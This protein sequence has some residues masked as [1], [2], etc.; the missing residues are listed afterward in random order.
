MQ[1]DTAEL[2]GLAVEGGLYGVF[3]CLFGVCGYDLMQRRARV[4]TQLSWPM[5]LAS[6]LLIIIATVRFVVDTAN[7]FVA[8]IRHDPRSLRIAYLTDVTQPLFTTR[9]SLLIV[10]LLIGDSFVNYRCWVVWGKRIWIVLFPIGLSF[11][12]TAI[13]SY[14]M[15]AYGNLPNQTFLSES[16]WLKAFFALSLVANAVA[17]LLLAFRIWSLDYQMAHTT[18]LDR[19]RFVRIAIDSGALN[20]LFL[21]VYVMTLNFGSQGLGIMSGMAVPFTGIV[22]FIVILRIGRQRHDDSFF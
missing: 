1:I 20:G 19:A 2:A 8:F 7:I 9:H 16:D 15:W 6:V 10:A 5:V 13:G 21:F 18:D 4:G 3:V 22:F 11:T 12:S 17:S 14:T